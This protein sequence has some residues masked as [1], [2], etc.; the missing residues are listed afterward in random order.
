MKT[1]IIIHWMP[2]KEDYFNPRGDTQTCC[3]WLPWIQKQL[4]MNGILAQT[5]EMPTPY[6]PQYNEWKRELERFDLNENIILIWHSWGAGFIVKRLSENNAKVG[7]VALV[8]PR[9]NAQWI[10]SY[11]FFD[12][13][14]DKDLV[15]K[16]ENT[17]VFISRD[18]SETIRDFNKLKKEIKNLDI[19]EFENKGH[20]CLKD[21]G[22]RVFPELLD[23]LIN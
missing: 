22:T 9:I 23:Y 4:I 10:D 7:K 13:K 6:L 2:S 17:R 3:H 19:L 5:I 20:F 1:A 18:D 12:F 8:A 11:D 21:L 16:T 14:I 15:K